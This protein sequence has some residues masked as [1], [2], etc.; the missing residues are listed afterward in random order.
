MK[1]HICSERCPDMFFDIYSENIASPAFWHILNSDMQFDLFSD[2]HP[3]KLKCHV[4]YLGP[5]P[6]GI[7]VS[8]MSVSQIFSICNVTQRCL[9]DTSAQ[10]C[11]FR[12]VHCLTENWQ[13]RWCWQ[14]ETRPCHWQAAEMAKSSRNSQHTLHNYHRHQH[15]T[16]IANH[17]LKFIVYFSSVYR[18]KTG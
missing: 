6:S 17:H 1:Y 11:R 9:S 5:S 4:E 13:R 3:N 14:I 12:E 7:G 18:V 10:H 15:T 16:T 2:L 8:D